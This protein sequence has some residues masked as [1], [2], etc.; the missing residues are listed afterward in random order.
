MFKKLLFLFKS[1]SDI[2]I[3]L[4]FLL[5]KIINIFNKKKIKIEKKYFLDS[6]LNLKISS[7]FFSVNAYNF[8]N[9]LSSLKKNFKYLEIG[10]FEGG[11][12]IY[13]SRRF[14]ESKI[15][16]VDNWI[17]TEDGYSKID[18]NDVEKNFDFNIEQYS[19]IYK[20]KKS[21]DNFFSDNLINFDVIYIDGYHKASQVYKDCLNAW[22]VLNLDG[23]LIC[24]DYIW[25][26]YT[27]IKDNP[28][29]A[30]NSFLSKIKGHYQILQVSNSQIFIKKIYN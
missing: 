14:D 10:S 3:I 28:C 22:K 1:K 8:Y 5:Q 7:E 4:L 25:D 20:I 26:H 2:K 6:L 16:C 30:V 27:E 19:N 13:I 18:F 17:K 29:F 11:S 24:D 21:S 9:H 15:Y 23:I 12:A